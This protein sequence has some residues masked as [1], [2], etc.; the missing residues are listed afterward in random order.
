MNCVNRTTR[1]YRRHSY[2]LCEQNNREGTGDIVMYC[3]NREGIGDIVMYC[4]NRTTRRYRRHSYAL[5]EQ[6]NKKV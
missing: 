4:V 3:V 6:N 1:R 5:C 2:V